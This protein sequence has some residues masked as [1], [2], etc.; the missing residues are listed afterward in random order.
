MCT[1]WLQSPKGSPGCGV[2]LGPGRMLRGSQCC[3]HLSLHRIHT[4][5]M[6]KQPGTDLWKPQGTG[7]E[8]QRQAP[9]SVGEA[10]ETL[11]CYPACAS[12]LFPV[13]LHPGPKMG[14]ARHQV[15]PPTTRHRRGRG[16]AGQG[17]GR[18]LMTSKGKHGECCSIG[19]SVFLS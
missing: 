14:G 8:S 2:P 4:P 12:P 10:W 15:L 5:P 1:Q 9:D 3:P 18:G 6:C 7:K 16:G 17:D 11:S 13:K 19:G